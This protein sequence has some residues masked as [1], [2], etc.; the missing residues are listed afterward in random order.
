MDISALG[1]SGADALNLTEGKTLDKQAFL[2][3][4]LKQLAVQDPLNPMDSTD[5]TAQLSQFSSLE[6]LNNIN[7]TLGDVLAYQESM[8]NAS[9]AGMIGKTVTASGNTAYLNGTADIR[10]DLSGDASSVKL[11]VMDRG[12]S[13]VWTGDA[14]EQ[15]GGAQSYAWNG[16]DLNGYQMSPGLY[17]FQ[18]DALDMSGNPLASSAVT[19]G[20]VT[21]VNFRDDATY[22]ELDGVRDIHLSEIESIQ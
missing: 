15:A 21:G 7:S 6:E 19:S 11:T 4:L 9:V 12:G 3:L 20:L 22:L 2:N 5:F 16:E 1:G 13:I 8:Q 18:V 14:G 10:Y 17:T